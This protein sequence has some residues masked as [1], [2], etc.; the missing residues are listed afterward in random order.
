MRWDITR[1]F[2]P[3]AVPFAILGA[4]LLTKLPAVYLEF[5]LGSFLLGNVLAAWFRDDRE[6]APRLGAR[7]EV[8]RSRAFLIVIGIAA[9]FISGFAGAVG[10]LFN[11][12]YIR[13]GL[14]KEEIVA[15]RAANEIMLHLVKI[16]TYAI[17][18]LMSGETVLI[19]ASIAFAALLATP[20]AKRVLGRLRE[21]LFRRLS[22]AA[23]GVA[24]IA[25]V[26]AAGNELSMRHG[27]SIAADL[28]EDEF[29][30]SV[31]WLTTELSG[32]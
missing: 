8:E 19:G 18:G 2:V 28:E 16:A 17:L 5:I 11:D 26:I 32:E 7:P 13:L 29:E 23:M 12:V 21:S 3:A 20:A 9:G 27:V 10:V 4:W 22:Y 24:G 6:P 15:T 25:M 31:R 14:T 1:W 30:V